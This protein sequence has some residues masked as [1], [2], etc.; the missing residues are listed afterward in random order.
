MC[1]YNEEHVNKVQLPICDYVE[2]EYVY[3]CIY[4]T[5]LSYTATVSNRLTVQESYFLHY[6]FIVLLYLTLR[7]NNNNCFTADLC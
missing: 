4:Y 6:A 5:H 7:N 1:I 2:Y 3:T